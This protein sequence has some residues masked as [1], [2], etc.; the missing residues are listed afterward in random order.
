L[1]SP[2][3]ATAQSAPL[4]GGKPGRGSLQ[5]FLEEQS[6]A[7]II[8]NPP[9]SDLPSAER[10]KRLAD[11][12]KKQPKIAPPQGEN[13]AAGRAPL[14]REGGLPP[15]AQD[16]GSTEGHRQEKIPPPPVRRLPSRTIR[17]HR[18]ST[19]HLPQESP[20]RLRRPIDRHPRCYPCPLG[21][22]QMPRLP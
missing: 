21:F 3:A 10:L 18:A 5:R 17:R 12:P 2:S 8:N 16:A 20:T 14:G 13:L 11:S 15:G 9:T 6:K 19:G 1:G 4:L 7:L 22:L